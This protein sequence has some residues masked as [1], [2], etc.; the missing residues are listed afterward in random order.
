MDIDRIRYFQVF[1]QMGSLVKASEVLHISQPALSKA[2]KLLESEVGLKLLEPDGRGL[3]LSDVGRAFQRE[4][5][6]LLAQ[7]MSLPERVKG[8]NQK[9]PTR[10]GSFEVFTT[11]FLGPLLAHTEL[12]KLEIHEYGPGKLEAALRDDIIDIGITY[13]PIPTAGTE[14]VE[15]TRIRMGVFGLAHKFKGVEFE[16]LPF[17]IPLQPAQGTPSKVIGL[18]GWPDHRFHRDI[19]FRVTMMESALEL[20]RSGVAV[21]YLPEFVVDLHNERLKTECRLAELAS[22]IPQKNRTQSVFLVQKQHRPEAQLH[23]Q[24]AKC[25]RALK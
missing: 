2:L 6:P 24:I 20:C 11:Y 10:I 16:N 12:A 14:F 5:A 1:S 9:P 23:R 19:R 18:D 13:L 8:A 22:P 17:V 21:A 15:V 7:W 3:R 4:T 25:L